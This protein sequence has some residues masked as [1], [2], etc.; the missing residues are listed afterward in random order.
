M[1]QFIGLDVHKRVVEACILDEQGK[2]VQRD[3]FPTTREDLEAFATKCLHPED[4]LTLEAT[5]NTWTIVDILEPHVAQVLISNPLR[6]KAI[7]SAKIKTDKVD[8]RVLAELLRADYLPC[9][10]QPDPLTRKVRRLTNHR[11]SLVGDQTAVKNRIHSML[12]DRLVHC[13]HNNL[14]SKSGRAWLEQVELDELARSLIDSDLRLLDAVA[15]EIGG[16]DAVLAGIAYEREQ[17]KLLMTLP[18][19]DFVVAMGVLSAIGKAYRFQEGDKMAS[20][21]GLTPSVK[22][23][24]NKCYRG[25]ITKAGNRRAR[26]LLIQAAQHL[27]RHP[28]PLGVFYRRLARKK[29]HNPAVVATAR[30]MAVIIWHMLKNNE[31]YRY[32][33]PKP[34]ETKLSRLRVRATGERRKG[35]TSKGTPRPKHYGEGKPRRR[36]RS[37]QGVYQNEGLPPLSPPK[38]GELKHM[39]QAKVVRYVLK[40]SSERFEPKKTKT[41]NKDGKT[42]EK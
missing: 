13:P 14:F 21:L 19:V 22:Q 31:P 5:T 18:G 2:V 37:L 38:D 36:I 28:G 32:A 35:G 1:V 17:A 15:T 41:K 8:A 9:V 25:P 40:T 39:E 4:R 12:H 3:R 24:A 11:A 16:I 27:I 29:G 6:T 23:S 7:A 42:K 26:W 33:Q 30:K 10:W 34:T 20:Y